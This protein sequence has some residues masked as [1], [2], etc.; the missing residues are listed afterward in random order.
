M[1]F[2][3]SD[4]QRQLQDSVGRFVRE[5]YP[6][7]Q[8]RK[9]TD[10]PEGFRAD[11]WRQMAELGWLGVSFSEDA[12]GF[13]GSAV[14]TMVVMEG[15]GRGLVAE[16]YL[17][18]VVLGGGFLQHGGSKAQKDELLPKLIEG[19]L[20]L[21]FA[22]AET[23]S[24]FALDDVATTAKAGDGG[25]I[26]NGRKIVVYDAPAADKL[27]V[28]A[29]TAGGPRDAAG[30]S[31]FLVDRDA[32]GVHLR[33]YRTLDRRRAADITF[34]NVKLGAGALIGT[35]D[36]GLPLMQLV[37]DHG[38]AALA[39]EAVGAMQLLT[40]TTNEYLKT[41]KQF[42]KPIGSFQALQHRMVDIFIATEQ[43]RSMSYMIAMK[44]DAPTIERTRA[45]S[46]AK[47]QIGQSGRFVGQQAVQLHGGMG[48]SDEMHVGHYMKRLMMIDMLFGNAD[49][50][51]D[52][53]IDL[54]DQ[55]AA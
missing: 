24:R 1:D 51:R 23:Q 4:E 27:V 11:N 3:L 12:G 5:R 2:S 44:L 38:I 9:I 18:T 46:A 40:D 25:Y 53:F 21:A 6:F 20:K 15:L 36:N 17:S 55:A 29:R 33:G 50:H 14:D 35:K 54:D 52:R 28:S 8:W 47:T 22:Q 30:I 49:F 13:G 42:G 19:N 41:R 31:L 37:V 7:D 32:P 26:L 16:P 39:A 48:M 45:A 34:D 43:A 10:T